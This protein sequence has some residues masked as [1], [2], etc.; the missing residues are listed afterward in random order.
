MRIDVKSMIIR[1]ARRI[2]RIGSGPGDLISPEANAAG[3]LM[4]RFAVRRTHTGAATIVIGSP[5]PRWSF[6]SLFTGIKL[7]TMRLQCER[8]VKN[9]LLVLLWAVAT[10][11]GKK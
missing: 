4:G 8:Q 10:R 7:F 2:W 6:F 9:D 5:A 3:Q 1:Y 11:R